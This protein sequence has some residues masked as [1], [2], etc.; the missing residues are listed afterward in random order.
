V[1]SKSPSN[2]E[3]SAV[4]LEQLKRFEEQKRERCWNAQERWRVIQQTMDWVDSQQA[5]GR[6]TKQ[7]CLAHQAKHHMRPS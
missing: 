7:A 6:N 3:D 1:R 5:I 4:N 2:S